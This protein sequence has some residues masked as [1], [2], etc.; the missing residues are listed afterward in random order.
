MKQ[1]G[2]D[3]WKIIAVWECRL[4]SGEVEKALK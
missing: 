3:G 4:K 1:P 2:K